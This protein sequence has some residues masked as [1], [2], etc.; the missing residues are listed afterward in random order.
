MDWQLLV[1][2]LTLLQVIAT[3]LQVIATSLAPHWKTALLGPSWGRS[4]TLLWAGLWFRMALELK[5]TQ[6][7]SNTIPCERC[8]WNRCVC[9]YYVCRQTV[10]NWCFP[11]KLGNEVQRVWF[12][13]YL[14]MYIV[15]KQN[16][17]YFLIPSLSSAELVT[18][19]KG[20]NISN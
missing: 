7:W 16:E 1:S 15:T 20:G 2:L 8:R 5:N 4:G 6:L 3:S 19:W 13:E 12:L 14:F 9:L 10:H 18:G 17:L 11:P